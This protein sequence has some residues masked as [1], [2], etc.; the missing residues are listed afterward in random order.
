MRKVLM[1]DLQGISSLRD[2]SRLRRPSEGYD[3][4]HIRPISGRDSLVRLL[5]SHLPSSGISK[6]LD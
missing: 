6:G 1:I 3:R 2:P 5:L 4:C